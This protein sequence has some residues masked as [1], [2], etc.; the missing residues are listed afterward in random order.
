MK[1]IEESWAIK[2]LDS[3]GTVKKHITGYNSR[4]EAGFAI[5][6]QGFITVPDGYTCV[7]GKN[8]FEVDEEPVKYSVEFYA[9]NS[10]HPNPN[11]IHIM[12]YLLGGEVVWSSRPN[13]RYTR[14]RV[15]VEE[16]V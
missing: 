5:S 2:I 11:A 7:I 14:Y 16:I 6:E 9:K 15:T 4:A 1:K 13:E 3:Q 8:T 10:L 12:T